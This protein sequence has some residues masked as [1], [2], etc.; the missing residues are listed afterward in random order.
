MADGEY[1]LG[2]AVV[3]GLAHGPDLDIT[4]EQVAPGEARDYK[5]RPLS[6]PQGVRSRRGSAPPALAGRMGKRESFLVS[7]RD[8]PAGLRWGAGGLTSVCL[9]VMSRSRSSRQHSI[10]TGGLVERFCRGPARPPTS[11]SRTSSRPPR[12]FRTM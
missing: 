3:K 1:Q 5:A 6:Y 9:G 7:N 10:A 2:D 11:A 12:G 4:A 8:L